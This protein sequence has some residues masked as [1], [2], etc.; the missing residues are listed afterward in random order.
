MC[1]FDFDAAQKPAHPPPPF[2]LVT[3]QV[4]VYQH[5][6]HILDYNTG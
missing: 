2:E 4:I 3:W 5:W 6:I 1:S